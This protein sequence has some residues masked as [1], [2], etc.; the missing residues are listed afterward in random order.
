MCVCV[1]VCVC[2]RNNLQGLICHETQP[3]NQLTNQWLK[4]PNYSL[5][6]FKSGNILKNRLY[7]IPIFYTTLTANKQTRKQMDFEKKYRPKRCF[8]HIE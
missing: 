7:Y 8:N 6:S 4:L 2:G 3:T 1:C 5:M